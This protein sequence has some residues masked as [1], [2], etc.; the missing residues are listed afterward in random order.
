[1]GERHDNTIPAKR[2]SYNISKTGVVYYFPVQ[3]G[4]F[5]QP[6][7]ALVMYRRADGEVFCSIDERWLPLKGSED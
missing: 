4:S 3:D 2:G 7:L 1:M 6:Q 5:M